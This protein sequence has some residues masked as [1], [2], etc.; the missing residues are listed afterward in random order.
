MPQNHQLF[1]KWCDTN[2]ITGFSLQSHVLFRSCGT[3]TCQTL[4]LLQYPRQSNSLGSWNPHSRWPAG[5]VIR[6]SWSTRYS[7]G[8]NMRKQHIERTK[9]RNIEKTCSKQMS[10]KHSK[11]WNVQWTHSL[12]LTNRMAFVLTLFNLFYQHRDFPT[13]ACPGCRKHLRHRGWSG[14]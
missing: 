2:K 11:Q 5:R 9:T 6:W 10:E 13:S 3:K 12:D 8:E 4:S 1:E 14:S 7:D